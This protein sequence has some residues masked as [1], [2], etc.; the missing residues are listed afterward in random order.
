M[1]LG[2]HTSKEDLVKESLMD[3]DLPTAASGAA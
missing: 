3:P 2:F 1:D